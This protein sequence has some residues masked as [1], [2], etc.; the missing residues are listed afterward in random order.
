MEE[1]WKAEVADM[2]ALLD[3]EIT[4]SRSIIE[5]AAIEKGIAEERQ[6]LALF[7]SRITAAFALQQQQQQCGSSLLKC[8]LK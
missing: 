4:N 8:G 2:H 5:K 1:Q 7:H 3:M 6:A